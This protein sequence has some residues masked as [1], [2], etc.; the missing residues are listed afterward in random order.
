MTSKEPAAGST[1]QRRGWLAS[2]ARIP[3][4]G[5][6]IALLIRVLLFSTAVTL[7]L[8]IL[9]LTLS[10]R[11]ERARLESRFG[12]IDQASSRSLSESLWALD[13]KQL[14]EQLEGIVRLPSIR[15]AEVRETAS[16]SHALTVL[17]GERQ[18]ARSVVKE[19]PLACCGD[20]PQVIGVLHI[21]A[22]LA[23]IY[24]DLAA[25]AVVILLSNAAK[26]FLVALFILFVVH[27][28]ATRHLLDIV[29]SIGNVTPQAQ[30]PPLQLRRQQSRGDELDQLVDALNAMRERLAQHA[31]ELGN[32]N[33]RMAII[34]DNIPDLAWVKDADGHYVA[35]NR[36]LATT[37]GFENPGQMIGKTDLDVH[38]PELSRSYLLDDAEVMASSTSKR[39]EEQHVRADGSS[40]LVETIKTALRDRD[41]RVTGTVGI[42]RDISGRQQA[43]ADRVA[44]HAAEAANQAKSEF[45]ANMSHEIRT[46][47]N[48]I[49]GMSY[50]ALQSGLDPQQ[51]NQVQ[52]IH[53]AAESLLGIIN[54]I[55]DFSKIE[56]GKLDIES[57]DFD[58]GDVLEGLGHLVGMNAEEKG[59]ELLIALPPQ[60]PRALVGDPS[61]L[62]QVLLNLGYNA[63]KFTERGEVV[64]AIAIA[65]RGA[66]T[67]DLRFEVRDTG[68]GMTPDEQQRLFQPFTQGDASTS[69]RYGGTG[70]GL[71]ISRRLV[72]LMGGEI[73][74][75]SAPRRGS[76]FRFTLR[77]GLQ[78]EPADTPVS[79]EAELRGR[80]A[81]VVDD[82]ACARELLASMCTAL[83]LDIDTAADGHAALRM[84][85]RADAAGTPYHLVLLDWKMPGLDGVECARLL[86]LDESRRHAAP[87]VLMVTAFGRDE[88]QRQLAQRQVR[89]GA[90]LTK[91]VSPS[92]LFDACG[93]ALGLARPRAPRA[94]QRQEAL[95]GHQAQLRGAQILL[96]EDNPINREIALSILG[97]ADIAVSVACD[98]RE[99]LQMLAGQRFDGVL[100]DC[101]MP[102]MDGYEATRAL[103]LQPQWRELPV[104]AMTANA[105]VGDRDKVL[106]A[107]MNDH[108][109][110]PINVDQLFATLARW[111]HP[112]AAA[113]DD[114]PA[115]DREAGITATMGDE[116]LYRR[117]MRMFRDRETDFAPRFRAARAAGEMATAMRMAHDLKN[118]AG[119]LA[120][121]AVHQA[122]AEL[123]RACI[124]EIDDAGVEPLLRK[125]ER[126]LGPVMAELVAL[127]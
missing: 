41:G 119:T 69:R 58:L 116:D 120:V 74:V 102:V 104:I 55:L 64:I 106:A 108:V 109:A 72:E 37:L 59:L 36:A 34:L 87:T 16:S 121:R 77:F 40:A 111:I 63:V 49:L 79:H 125:V 85:R 4:G 42:A 96:V 29:A 51:L 12:E 22:T 56:A 26:T 124:D 73:G 18:T 52:K 39:I 48:A 114:S 110:K 80:R 3:G 123:E 66:G 84:A 113:P 122:A 101:Q 53:G 70:L 47:M 78:P 7:L 57:I 25:Q 93:E 94:M 127:G 1:P 15:A 112:A 68:I 27:R 65:G 89:V 38:P 45:L 99:A 54:D 24:R 97:R 50:L 90:L 43:E 81:L 5:I 91:P 115:I 20:H 9:Q 31:A 28:L 30:A 92:T 82:N 46:P 33:A 62:R 60:L 83:G 105:L 17:R 8:T 11:S 103:R 98:G 6:A 2:V 67:I 13:S 107:G 19:F 71:S 61:R 44:R 95:H 14:E 32:A 23:D 100:M 35:V 118:V 75:D 117:L 126:L 21:E 86:S 88:A 76:I 10:Y